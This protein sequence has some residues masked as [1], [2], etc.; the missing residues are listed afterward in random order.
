MRRILSAAA[1]IVLGSLVSVAS[2]AQAASGPWSVLSAGGLHTCAIN[3]SKS[4]YCW[5]SNG[6]SQIGDGT[7]TPRPSPT[8]IGASGVWAGVSAGTNHTCA[9]TTGQSLYCWGYNQYGQVGDGTTGNLRPSPKKVGSSGVWAGVAAGGGHTCATTTGK[10]LYCWGH[11][12]NGQVGDGTVTLRP[13]PKKIGASGVWTGATGGRS[14]TCALTTGNSLYCWGLN[15]QGQVGDGTGAER[16]S[17]TKIGASGVWLRAEVGDL[18]TCAVTTGASL[19]CWGNNAT[20]QLGDG[21]INQTLSPKK[22]G[23]SGVWARVSAGGVN[24]VSH[25]CATT[26]GSSLYCWGNNGLGAVGDGTNTTPRLSPTKVG[27]SGVWAGASAG[28]YHSCAITTG[29]ALYCWGYNEFGQ[30]GD[31]TDNNTRLSPKKIP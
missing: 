9:V 27:S 23:A 11:N 2:P 12:V 20:G 21:T 22:I 6:L 17:P 30:V 16:H 26:T 10:S 18:H 24:G 5:G 13:S 1:V 7:S 31:G 15:G 14:H 25:T 28:G 3:T 8:K 19:Y 29:K 4:L